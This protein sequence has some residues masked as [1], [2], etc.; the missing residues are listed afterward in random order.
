MEAISSAFGA[1][2]PGA[3]HDHEHSATHEGSAKPSRRL[4]IDP[5]D[6]YSPCRRFSDPYAQSCWLF[7]GFV[8]LRQ[9]G[10][11]PGRAFHVCDAAPDGR[12]ARCYESV[13]HQLTGLFQYDDTW[14]LEQCSRGRA[15]LA[16][17][18]AAG[19]ALAL[20]ALDWSGTRAARLCAS[21]PAAWKEACYRSASGALVDL[22]PA[23]QRAQFCASIETAYAKACRE[24][25]G[26]NVPRGP[27]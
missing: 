13:G 10:F 3:S 2:K 26:A 19:A 6:P 11:D 7:Q 8:I 1:P 21:A 24:S 12:A 22:A 20:D 18:C 15:D 5:S 9:N 14:I 17:S 27:S 25:V 23:S 16:P 4:S